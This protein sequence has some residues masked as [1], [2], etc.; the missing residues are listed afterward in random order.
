MTFA[1]TGF[2]IDEASGQCLCTSKDSYCPNLS[3]TQKRYDFQWKECN[4][5]SLGTEY[6]KKTF[7]ICAS[8]INN[9]NTRSVFEPLET[10]TDCQAA[11]QILEL[12]DTD[13]QT[14]EINSAANPPGCYHFSGNSVVFNAAS[15]TEQCSETR[16]CICKKTNFLRSGSRI[17]C[18]S[19]E[20]AVA[21]RII[22]N[23]HSDFLG[24]LEAEI[25][26]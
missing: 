17:P 20:E 7:G 3:N 8:T 26:L 18:E 24:I 10:A 9:K 15:S 12:E 23:G 5:V 25:H 16:P 1:T 19:N 21:V 13:G 4:S 6:A 2:L 11:A 14:G 22:Q